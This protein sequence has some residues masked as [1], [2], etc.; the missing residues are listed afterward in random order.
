VT[1]PTALW[2][3]LAGGLG[4]RYGEPK[5][6][7]VYHG[8]RFLD[9]A[10]GIV[11]ESCAT[12]DRIVVCLRDGQ[13][14]SA[15]A[16][17]MPPYEVVRDGPARQGPVAGLLAA[18]TAAKEHD[19]LV[20]LPVDMP[21]LS[22]EILHGLK[23][24]AV[25]SRRAVVATSA[26]SGDIHWTLSAIPRHLLPEVERSANGGATSLRRVFTELD[27]VGVP[28]DDSLLANINHRPL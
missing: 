2:A 21:L 1:P 20:T 5:Y 10:L 22:V 14:W 28:F 8:I 4:T 11:M 19:I 6:S 13:E 7:A 23:L 26:Q 18:T 25:A 24:Q 3:I 12:A 15:E 27:F 17:T 9:R 16:S